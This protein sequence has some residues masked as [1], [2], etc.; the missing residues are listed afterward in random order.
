MANP[1]DDDRLLD[2][3]YDG[4]Q[5]FD[6]PLPRWWVWI[7]WA[8]IVFSV[9]YVFDVTGRLAG[10]GRVQEYEREMAAAAERWPAPS[11]PVDA[12]SL[13]AMA[14][15]PATVAAGAQVFATNCV[16]CHRADGGGLIGPN[17]TDDFWIHG[18]SLPEIHQVVSDGVLDKGMPP[19]SK[20]L[21]PAQVNAVVAYVHSLYGTTPPQPKAAEGTRVERQ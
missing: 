8:T 13:A 2:H 20:V 9:L 4:I 3:S 1:S 17:L 21:S 10:P 6:N 11:G 14:A 7:F 12:A 18:G 19:W 16:A 15:D 5:E